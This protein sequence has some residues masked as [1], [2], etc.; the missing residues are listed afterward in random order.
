MPE[1]LWQA[2]TEVARK[3]GMWAT[4]RALRVRYD[5]LK[6]R[7]GTSAESTA[8]ATVFCG[9]GSMASAASTSDGTTVVELSRGDG[10]RLTVRL[11]RGGLDARSLIDAFC[12]VGR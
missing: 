10:A 5:G 3:H 1:D 12:G 8:A 11:T 9:I 6:A 2:A 7:L 4:S